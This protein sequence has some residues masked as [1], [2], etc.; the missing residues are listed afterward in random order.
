MNEL[1]AIEAANK[2]VDGII[3]AQSL[4]DGFAPSEIGGKA[5]AEFIKALH[6]ALTAYYKTLPE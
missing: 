5:C 2:T 4:P 6:A 1:D 3:K